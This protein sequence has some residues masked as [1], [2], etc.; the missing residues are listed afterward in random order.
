MQPGV[1][2][3]S[4][5]TNADV[6]D[7][8]EM[9]RERYPKSVLVSDDGTNAG[10][11]ILLWTKGSFLRFEA[12]FRYF[13]V[14]HY[15]RKKEEVEMLPISILIRLCLNPRYIAESKAW[16]TAMQTLNKWFES[17][18][19]KEFNVRD[20]VALYKTRKR[21]LFAK[22]VETKNEEDESWGEHQIIH[23]FSEGVMLDL[24]FMGIIVERGDETFGD[25]LTIIM[26]K[27]IA[28]THL[29]L[30]HNEI[31]HLPKQL[32]QL[33]P[34]LR[35]LHL[36]F[37]PLKS[38][39]PDA[40][41]AVPNLEYLYLESVD[42]QD[43]SFFGSLRKVER[44]Y[45]YP[46]SGIL[47]IS[48]CEPIL[49][50]E[51]RWKLLFTIWEKTQ[52]RIPFKL[53]KLKLRIMYTR[54]AIARKKFRGFRVDERGTVIGKLGEGFQDFKKLKTAIRLAE[55]LDLEGNGKIPYHF[56]SSLRLKYLKLH[57]YKWDDGTM[58][59][60]G[61][62]VEEMILE[63]C[64]GPLHS[65]PKLKRLIIEGSDIKPI[66][67][68][69]LVETI[70][71][72]RSTVEFI[73]GTFSNLQHLE[74]RDSEVQG[75]GEQIREQHS[76]KTLI[77]DSMNIR[78]WAPYLLVGDLVDVALINCDIEE[79]NPYDL[80]KVERLNL[81]GNRLRVFP[82]KLPEGLTSLV[83]DANPIEFVSQRLV[84]QPSLH[85]L[86]LNHTQI[87]EFPEVFRV[88]NRHMTVSLKQTRIKQI[89]MWVLDCPLR[90]NVEGV[91]LF[92]RIN[93]GTHDTFFKEAVQTSHLLQNIPNAEKWLEI[94]QRRLRY[95]QYGVLKC[96]KAGIVEQDL[97]MIAASIKYTNLIL[98]GKNLENFPFQSL[99][100]SVERL[101]VSNVDT[102]EIV[103]D[104]L[105]LRE[106]RIKES[107]KLY[108]FM[109]GKSSIDDLVVRDC[110]QLALTD[111]FDRLPRIS[112]LEWIGTQL[113]SFDLKKSRELMDVLKSEFMEMGIFRQKWDWVFKDNRFSADTLVG[114]YEA[115]ASTGAI[116]VLKFDPRTRQLTIIVNNKLLIEQVL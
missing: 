57:G 92:P 81:H 58:K 35:E 110:P 91:P 46:S 18:S 53:E 109:I 30:S 54:D 59:P 108:K 51:T 104:S 50:Y 36:S 99:P 67:D 77:I 21:E 17:E 69:P 29:D 114:F 105:N 85:Y 102:Q 103:L 22:L 6:S 56:F 8:I 12:L 27:R 41:L 90:L 76:L 19:G 34:K 11:A 98:E 40:F 60:L 13:P 10:N 38:I 15:L 87:R 16:Q 84:D 115:M 94:E 52:T 44:V 9:V 97:K 112:K 95:R 26:K 3:V 100:D 101:V 33:F 96:T 47:Q 86:S 70:V 74:L 25:I 75:L 107:K 48:K 37:N 82:E 64:T 106:I 32:L 65:F 93:A 113:N 71:I 20:V 62:T 5:Y 61:Q 2:R 43:F 111:L 42:L 83:L 28:I 55:R 7:L 73:Q 45:M 116:C 1:W 68:I 79:F 88:M 14:R 4:H 78:G 80:G 89:P 66:R 63:K 31:H 23:K 39:D 72:K 49:R 24:S